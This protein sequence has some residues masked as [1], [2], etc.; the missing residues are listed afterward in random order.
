MYGTVCILVFKPLL[1]FFLKTKEKLQN[2][3][4]QNIFRE[5]NKISISKYMF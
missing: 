5:K 1:F 2:R 3:Y 4:L